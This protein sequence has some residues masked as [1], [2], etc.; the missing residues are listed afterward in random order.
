MV[1]RQCFCIRSTSR[2]A[3]CLAASS[4]EMLPGSH[5]LRLTTHA[6]GAGGTVPRAGASPP[7]LPLSPLRVKPEHGVPGRR[8][9]IAGL[10][11]RAAQT[12]MCTE[13]AVSTAFINGPSSALTPTAAPPLQVTRSGARGPRRGWEGGGTLCGSCFGPTAN[14]LTHAARGVLFPAARPSMRTVLFADTGFLQLRQKTRSEVRLK[15]SSGPGASSGHVL[16][17]QHP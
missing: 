14:L 1:Q 13:A 9:Q 2:P 15:P 7:N 12:A 6:G 8:Q 16:A 10:P 17:E 3:G 4:R 11:H 5:A